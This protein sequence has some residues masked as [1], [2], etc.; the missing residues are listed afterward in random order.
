MIRVTEALALVRQACAPL[1]AESVPLAEAFGRVLAADL[2][3]DVDWPPFDASA[4]DGYA[5]RA[6]DAAAGRPLRERSGLVAAGDAPPEPLAPGEAVRVMTGASIPAGTDAVVP[7]EN[8]RREDGAVVATTAP[9]AG[10]HVRRRGESI[11]AGATLVSR[12][13]RL[14]AAETALA[15]LAGADPLSVFRRPR[16]ALAATGNE[17]VAST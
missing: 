7:V 13:R 3:S 14:G 15:A 8:A 11:V 4:M 10:E 1:A 2:S 9:A 16:V 6:A 12:G 5:V 17:L